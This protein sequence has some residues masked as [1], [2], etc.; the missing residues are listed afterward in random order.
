MDPSII[1]AE[2]RELLV[3]DQ[4]PLIEEALGACQSAFAS[5]ERLRAQLERHESRDRP[6]YERWYHTHFGRQLTEIRELS[7]LILERQ[8][9]LASLRKRHW[10]SFF[11]GQPGIR[12]E[13]RPGF[14]EEDLEGFRTGHF[15]EG[16]DENNDDDELGF[17]YEEQREF[18]DEYES[19]R[20]KE[21]EREFEEALR[22]G[23]DWRSTRGQ[24]R[25]RGP[26][27]G[28]DRSRARFY[29]EECGRDRRRDEREAPS[30]RREPIDVPAD[31]RARLKERYR[32]LVRKLHPDLNPDQSVEQK[33]LWHRVQAAYEKADLE[34]LDLLLALS[35]AFA[36]TVSEVTG[37][38]HLRNAAQE[39][40]RLIEPLKRKL[41]QLQEERAWEFS[42]REDLW[43]IEG[44]VRA[45]F[46]RDL[47]VLRAK[48]AEVDRQVA[49]FAR[50]PSGVMESL[51]TEE[52]R[53]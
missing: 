37:L 36:G 8:A 29:S 11:G 44:E 34:Q 46:E 30:A 38:G 4:L 17:E 52:A 26:S 42:V 7:A 43:R 1:P 14:E 51:E 20:D 21:S 28:S 22:D 49:R 53:P 39:I 41:A 15:D 47:R 18:Q 3:V 33:S 25:S 16:F 23:A 40:E 6:A 31:A 5:I 9:R 45:E 10:N 32:A 27:D 13:D 12:A 48:L 50:A 24:Y 35:D 2:S 19:E